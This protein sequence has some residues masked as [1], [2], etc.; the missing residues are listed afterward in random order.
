MDKFDVD[1]YQFPQ[2]SSKK[3]STVLFG[4]SVDKSIP[5][6]ALCESFG[7]KIAAQKMLLFVLQKI[8]TL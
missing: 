1:F 2:T 5:V 6:D 8:S 7:F 3:D 4:G